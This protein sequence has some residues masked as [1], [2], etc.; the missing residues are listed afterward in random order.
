QPRLRNG[1]AGRPRA[2]AE[3][4]LGRLCQRPHREGVRALQLLGVAVVAVL[5]LEPDPEHVL[6]QPPRSLDV[7]ADWAKPRDEEHLH[8]RTALSISRFASRSAIA[9]RLSNCR[10][11][12]HSPTS[13]L[14]WLRLK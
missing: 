1:D 7:T 10:L 8:L 13:T 4:R 11:P 12:R 9:C 2:R 6:V 3:A 14:A 5:D